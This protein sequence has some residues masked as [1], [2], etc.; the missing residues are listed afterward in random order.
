MT[1]RNKVLKSVN[2]PDGNLC[3][4]IFRRPDGTFGFAQY[5]RDVE[6]NRGWFPVGNS[7]EAV[8]DTPADAWRGAVS[9]VVWLGIDR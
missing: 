1:V 4:D 3:V 9:T 5:R 6:D 2:D 7:G 8:F